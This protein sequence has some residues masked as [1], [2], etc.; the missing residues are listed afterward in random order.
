MMV[1]MMLWR[2]VLVSGLFCQVARAEM[3]RV[4][5][6]ISLREAMTEIAKMYKAD[7]SDDVEL[8]FG[9]SG[10]LAAQ[11]EN[12]AR[13]DLFISAANAQVEQLVKDRLV[14]QAT[15]RV[16]AGNDLVLIV[17][18][19]AK[20]PPTGFKD[21]AERR[22][23]RIAIGNPKTVPAGEYAM[24]TLKAMKLAEAVEAR[25]IFGTNVR[26][27]LDYVERG[28]VSAGVVYAT[29][30]REAGERVKV[31][32]KA[33]A[34]THKPI[35]YPAVI[36]RSSKNPAAAKRFLDYLGGEKARKIL[37]EKGFVVADAKARNP[38][39]EIRKIDE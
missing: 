38:K 24:Q 16:V 17:P 14:D 25:L 11:I 1:E 29:D 28:E 22:F 18:A 37:A 9:S 27:V 6:A 12:G 15:R 32:E 36:I 34:A 33:E 21:L 31:V 39:P 4:G 3:I 5:A 13:I 20:D 26:Q 35:E 7:V 2:V 10:Q 8:N 19:A 30:A 23:K